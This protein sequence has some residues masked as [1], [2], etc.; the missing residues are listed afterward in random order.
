MSCMMK[1]DLRKPHVCNV[2]KQEG[3]FYHKKWW[4]G[5][6]KYLEGYCKNDKG[7]RS[8]KKE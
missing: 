2:C 8:S 6:S 3:K 1:I 5:H 4:C 7:K